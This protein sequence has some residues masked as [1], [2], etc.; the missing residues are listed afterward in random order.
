V[1]DF[2]LNLACR[3]AGV[4]TG[5]VQ[6]P[7]LSALGDAAGEP[8]NQAMAVGALD[9][10]QS[11]GTPVAQRAAP[12][13][14][15]IPP[16]QRSA[17]EA[18]PPPT[19]GR[20]S[21]PAGPAR[22]LEGDLLAPPAPL[23]RDA[24]ADPIV[25]H[26]APVAAAWRPIGPRREPDRDAAPFIADDDRAVRRLESAPRAAITVP[27]SDGSRSVEPIAT[28]VDGS[29]PRPLVRPAA[30]GSPMP[31]LPRRASSIPPAAATPAPVHVRI[32][33]IEV[34]GAPGPPP[35]SSRPA[36]AALG[37][38]RYTRLRTYRTGSP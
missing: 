6:P 20:S 1:S 26:P 15:Q 16:I 17:L 30:A 13:L 18:A 10:P 29:G 36:T 5:A 11:G 28:R 23:R 7:A 12:P 38:T 37:F 34:R 25:E 14:P 2:L 9:V 35:P 32:G 3:A 24:P 22:P 27:A 4:S 8:E 21:S 31:D 19:A 33:R